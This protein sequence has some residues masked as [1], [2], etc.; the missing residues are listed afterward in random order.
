MKKIIY[1][2]AGALAAM[3]MAPQAFAI[4]GY[5]RQTGM[6]CNACHFQSFPILNE[7]GRSFKAGGYTMIGSQPKIEGS[8][9]LS[10]PDTLNASVVTKIRYQKSNGPKS[11]GSITA[12]TNDGQLQFP[13]EL[14]LMVGGRASENI[15][16]Q[17]EMDLNGGS[18]VVAN[19]KIPFIYD[20]GGVKAGVVPFTT[21]NQGVSYGFELLNTGAVRGSRIMEARSSFSAQ[22]YIG[23]GTA[24]E[25][26]AVVASNSMYFAN[27]TKWSPRSV[28]A[29]TTGSPTANYFRLAVTPKLGSWDT[30]LGVQSWSGN[31]TNAAG[32]NMTTK[33]YALDAQAQGEV[34]TMPL[35]IYLTHANANASVAG[36]A[37]NLFNSQAKAKT[38]TTIAGQLGVSPGKATLL[39][40]YRKGDNGKATGNGDNS[41]TIGGTY[42]IVQNVQLQLDHEMFSGSAYD[43]TPANGN[44]LTTLMLFA[45]F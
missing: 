2:L 14:L 21:A 37:P 42:Q 45:A 24:A 12:G 10:L 35:G 7:F 25:G 9:G 26:I 29:A 11:A 27:I 22:Q 18:P 36:T 4:P 17:L 39:M 31:A 3:A 6:A 19:F 44:R 16:V 33:A 20:V 30:G 5:S 8:E 43:G 32:T 1:L 23:T 28:G 15:G 34:A 38:A 13:D 40:S 41:L